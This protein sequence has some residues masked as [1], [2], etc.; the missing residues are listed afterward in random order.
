MDD[1]TVTVKSSM[2]TAAIISY[3]PIFGPETEVYF[4]LPEFVLP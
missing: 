3:L 4:A 1:F 2:L